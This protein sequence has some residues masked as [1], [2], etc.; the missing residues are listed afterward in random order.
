MTRGR[1]LLGQLVLVL[2]VMAAAFVGTKLGMLGTRE[3]GASHNFSDVPDSVFYHD[4]VQFLVDAGLT[5]GC[6]V[7]P[8]LYCGEQSVTRGQM[9]VF[10]QRL[11]DVVNQNV[12]AQVAGLSAQVATL[13]A[14]LNGFEI[15]RNPGALTNSTVTTNAVGCPTGKR[16]LA[17]GGTTDLSNLFMTDI[18]IFN[19][20]VSVRWETDNNVLL[21]GTTE[22]WVLCAPV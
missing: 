11:A 17:G 19:T 22:A 6:S 21:T 9:A 16:A 3:V 15:V 2:A 18:A 13:S 1:R 8:P 5:S 14:Q 10:I 7:A 12:N 4:S 20:S